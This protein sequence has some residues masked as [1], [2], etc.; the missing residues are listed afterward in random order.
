MSQRKVYNLIAAGELRPIK[1]GRANR[2]TPAMIDAYLRQ[3]V[4]V[5]ARVGAEDARL[6]SGFAGHG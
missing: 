4:K 2:F 6:V 3:T 5:A 1:I